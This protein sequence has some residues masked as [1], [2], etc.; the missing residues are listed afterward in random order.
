MLKEYSNHSDLTKSIFYLIYLCIC[1]AD[2][3]DSGGPD[4][5]YVAKIGLKHC[6][7]LMGEKVGGQ[8]HKN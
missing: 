2:A 3:K 1:E 5:R 7:F 4:R 6:N 8:T